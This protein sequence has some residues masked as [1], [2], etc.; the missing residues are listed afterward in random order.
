MRRELRKIIL[1]RNNVTVPCDK[2]EGAV[3]LLYRHE[4]TVG[5]VDDL[6]VYVQIIIDSGYRVEEIARI[7]KTM[8]T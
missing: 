5:L 6:P 1:V 8:A 4:L 7:G 2:I 3:V